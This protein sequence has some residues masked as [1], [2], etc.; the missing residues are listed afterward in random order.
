R[1]ITGA[2]LLCPFDPL[3]WD[4]ARTQRLFGFRYRIEIYVPRHRRSHGYYVLPLL[5]DGQLVARVDLKADRSAGLLRVPGAFAEPGLADTSRVVAELAMALRE[6]A[7]WLELDGI[8]PGERGDLMAALGVVT[9][10]SPDPVRARTRSATLPSAGAPL[11][12]RSLRACPE[13]DLTSS[14]A[15]TPRWMP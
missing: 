8:A 4:R 6:M 13:P 14:S 5:L 1:R 9:S 11:T 2:A 15:S 3:I 7:E 12:G 10:A